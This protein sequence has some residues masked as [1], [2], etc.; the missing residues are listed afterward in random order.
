MGGA[1]HDRSTERGGKVGLVGTGTDNIG[2]MG[3]AEVGDG[4]VDE[5]QTAAVCP[6]LQIEVSEGEVD[7]ERPSEVVHAHSQFG[8]SHRSVLIDLLRKT[9]RMERVWSGSP[10][11]L[12]W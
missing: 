6:A 8:L 4:V 10:V 1:D 11:R 7:L 9:F 2:R 5:A 3:A 12:R